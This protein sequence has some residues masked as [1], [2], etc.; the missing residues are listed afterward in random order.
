MLKSVGCNLFDRLAGG[1]SLLHAPC[2]NLSAPIYLI[3][4]RV[5][6]LSYTP[7]ALNLSGPT[8][9]EESILYAPSWHQSRQFGG[10]GVSITCTVLESDSSMSGW[11]DFLKRP[12]CK[13][14]SPTDEQ[15]DRFQNGALTE[16][17]YTP[18][19]HTD[20]ITVPVREHPPPT[21][22]RRDT[23]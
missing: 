9:G 8:S 16:I 1:E 7:R 21:N 13:R 23:Y 2:W 5:G 4:W 6:S 11:G 19:Q 3:V 22:T 20:S 17:P 12:V 14:D 15:R 10:W 18:N